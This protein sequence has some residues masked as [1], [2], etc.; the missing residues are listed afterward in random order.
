MT[1]ME[2]AV[3]TPS[4]RNYL[5][6]DRNDGGYGN[7]GDCATFTVEVETGRFPM[8]RDCG[9][10]RSSKETGK[11]KGMAPKKTTGEVPLPEGV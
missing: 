9:W 7:G 5:R 1:G 2:N 4:L 11:E 8:N 6:L 10:Q 3:T